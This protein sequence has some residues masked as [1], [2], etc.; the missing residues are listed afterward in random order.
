MLPSYRVE[1]PKLTCEHTARLP[2]APVL[3]CHAINWVLE[4]VPHDS[5]MMVCN[6]CFTAFVWIDDKVLFSK[7][8]VHLES[9][10]EYFETKTSSLDFYLSWTKT[11]V[12]NLT[13][14]IMATLLRKLK[15]LSISAPH[16]ALREYT[17][18]K[19]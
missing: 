1:K 5:E 12:P 3:F 13:L 18:M 11:K 9:T 7:L 2:P 10:M 14:K 17:Y 15:N 19:P 8:P 16:S 4:K 6:I